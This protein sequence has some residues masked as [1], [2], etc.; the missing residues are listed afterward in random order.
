MPASGPYLP[1][2]LGTTVPLSSSLAPAMLA[3][4]TGFCPVA[5]I[6]QMLP[7]RATAIRSPPKSPAWSKTTSL[8]A[9][10]SPGRFTQAVLT[11][12]P[13]LL[14]LATWPALAVGL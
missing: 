7:E 9:A 6:R 4:L 11:V 1:G 14:I 3:I 2:F 5:L 8:S 13:L 10:A 12:A